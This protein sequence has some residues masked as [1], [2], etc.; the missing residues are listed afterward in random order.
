[1]NSLLKVPGESDSLNQGT[2]IGLC[3]CKNLV[4]LEGEMW[5]DEDFTAGSRAVPGANCDQSKCAA[6]GASRCLDAFEA[7]AKYEITGFSTCWR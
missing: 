4:G 6:F 5:L 3:L 2:G 7:S 1:M